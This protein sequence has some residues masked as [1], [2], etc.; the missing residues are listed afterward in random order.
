[1]KQKRLVLK[2]ELDVNA[3]GA[4]DVEI[5]PLIIPLKTPEAVAMAEGLVFLADQMDKQPGDGAF[6]DTEA[7]TLPVIRLFGVKITVKANETTR[8][9]IEEVEVPA[10][11]SAKQ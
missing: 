11:A 6:T 1:M 4:Q 7:I 9:F 2:I 10:P 8:L 3:D 5:T